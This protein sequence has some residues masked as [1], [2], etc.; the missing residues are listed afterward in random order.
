[1]AKENAMP[2]RSIAGQKS[3]LARD[4][5]DIRYDAVH[6]E[7]FVTQ[8]RAQA[9]LAFRG[10]ADGEEA[11]IRIIQG[12]HTQLL[13][14]PGGGT[15]DRLDVDVVHNEILVASGSSVLAFPRDGNGDV[16]PLRVLRGPDTGLDFPSSVVVDPVHNVLAVGNGYSNYEKLGEGVVAMR[17]IARPGNPGN[18]LLYNRTDEGNVKPRA[19]IQGP[20]TGIIRINQMQMYPPK[21][22]IIVTQPGNVD[23]QEPVGTFVGIW[24]IN[25]NGDLPPRWILRG[26]KSLLMK[27]RGIVLDL[28]HKEMIVADMRLNAVLT[29]S[30]PEIF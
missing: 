30:F 13:G 9:I 19:V 26:P 29:Y 24:S 20:K 27:P 8:P 6:D 14:S 17:L 22:W 28:K 12:P 21:G 7:I 5:H 4:I 10:G 15:L 2:V 11:P 23:A 25:D 16:A 1:L 3:L 18:L